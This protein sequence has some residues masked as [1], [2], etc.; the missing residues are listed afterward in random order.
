[1][2]IY[3]TTLSLKIIYEMAIIDFYHHQ[4]FNSINLRIIIDQYRI[5]KYLADFVMSLIDRNVTSN[6]LLQIV[7]HKIIL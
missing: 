4:I 3:V 7:H 5:I 6:E 1:M 2:Y